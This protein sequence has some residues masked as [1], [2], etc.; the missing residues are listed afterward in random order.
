MSDA[1]IQVMPGFP[2]L[3]SRGVRYTTVLDWIVYV[4]DNADIRLTPVEFSVG[5]LHGSYDRG[6]NSWLSGNQV[7]KKLKTKPQTA[8]AATDHLVDLGLLT[9]IG[10]FKGQPHQF[11]FALTIPT[12]T[13]GMAEE[14]QG[15]MSEETHV[16]E[17][18]VPMDTP[19]MS[20]ETHPYVPTDTHDVD[21][22]LEL[23][24]EP[25]SEVTALKANPEEAIE[26]ALLDNG[27][28]DRFPSQLAMETQAKR[29]AKKGLCPDDAVA[30]AQRIPVVPKGKRGR[31]RNVEG[32]PGTGLNLEA[33]R[34]VEARRANVVD[35]S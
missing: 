28:R 1:Q 7:A 17:K 16:V 4:R 27:L 32:V 19:R 13:F 5:V 31:V 35:V 3:E 34:R 30:A 15:G 25:G 12:E 6:R 14:T 22:D 8:N 10:T 9:P 2:T 18:Y 24:V 23:D 20:E 29:W 21:L 11:R 33:L 26:L